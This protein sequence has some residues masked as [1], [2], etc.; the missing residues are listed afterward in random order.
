MTQFIIKGETNIF[1]HFSL[2]LIDKILPQGKVFQGGD[3]GEEDVE[4]GDISG[5]QRFRGGLDDHSSS[6]S[7][8]QICGV[9]RGRAQERDTPY[10]PH[11]GA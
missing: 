6:Q 7:K 5:L 11:G 2:Y 4:C 1:E 8:T 3:A 10:T 9:S